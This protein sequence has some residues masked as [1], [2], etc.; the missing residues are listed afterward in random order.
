MGGREIP[1]P[2]ETR[3]RARLLAAMRQDATK[4]GTAPGG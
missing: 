3:R 2:F 4:P 1:S